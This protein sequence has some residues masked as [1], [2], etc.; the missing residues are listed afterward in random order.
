MM[1]GRGR[2]R[3]LMCGACGKPYISRKPTECCSRQC[4][5]VLRHRRLG[6]TV[7]VVCAVCGTGFESPISSKAIYCSRACYRQRATTHTR[8]FICAMCGASV[9]R[10][11]RGARA[12]YCS[13]ACRANSR[14][15]GG[16][17]SSQG[18]RVQHINGKPVLEHRLV[19]ERILGR[20]L[21][22]TESVH[23]KNG[24]RADNAAANLELWDKAQPPGQRVEDKL[25]W[26]VSYL[27][28][29]GYHVTIPQS[30]GQPSAW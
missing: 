25:A 21:K 16:T 12:T 28:E 20:P 17:T 30:R 29:H 10:G 9:A 19:M 27:T 4:A 14:R 24:Q 23:H 6:R 15:K 22:A 18:Y 2:K 1:T 3:P 7:P 26:C 11:L 8:Y 5:A 13:L